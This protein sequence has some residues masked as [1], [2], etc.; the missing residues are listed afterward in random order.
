MLRGADGPAVGLVDPAGAGVERERQRSFD[1]CAGPTQIEFDGAAVTSLLD[2]ARAESWWASLVDLGRLCV[3]SELSGALAALFEQSLAYAREREQFDRP[4]GSFQVVQH[5]LADIWTQTLAAAA[6]CDAAAIA[7]VEDASAQALAAKAFSA[8]VA[9]PT[10]EAALQIHGAIGYTRER[11]LH[12]YLKRILTLTGRYGDAFELQRGV[13]R[14][15][16]VERGL[17]G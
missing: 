9:L 1:V 16:V 12:F 6:I 5:A 15:L 7:A 2:G 13:G 10:A 3:A 8:E 14:G 17:G 4:I 11:P